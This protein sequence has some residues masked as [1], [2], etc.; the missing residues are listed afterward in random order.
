MITKASSGTVKVTVTDATKATGSASFTWTAKNTI[1]V[2]NPGAQTTTAG[3]PVSV[4]VPAADDDKATTLAWTASGLPSGLSIGAATGIITGEPALNGT[5]QVTVKVTD[6][7]G[8]A[9]STA[10]TWKVGD[11]ITVSAPGSEHSTVSIPIVPVKVTAA[12]SAKGRTLSYSAANLPPGLAIN[13]TTG[14]ISG[15]PA[16]KA[17]GYAATVT[18]KDGTGA[19]D[20]AP[21]G[22]TIANLVTVQTPASEQSFAGIAVSVHAKATDSDPAQKLSY[23]AAGLPASLAIN[24][25][26]GVIYGM[27]TTNGEGIVTVTVTDGAGSSGTAGVTWTVGDAITHPPPR[28]GVRHGGRGAYLAD[29]LH[30]HRA[31]RQSRACPCTACRPALPSRPARRRSSAGRL[32]PGTYPVTVVATGSLGD[33]QSMT[34]DDRRAAR[35]GRRSCRADPA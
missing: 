14:V 24:P 32:K 17:A 16:G 34:F 20:S 15:I 3:S 25:A 18:A 35:V 12:D 13:A 30:R 5:Y 9:A 4:A 33:S 7:T 6:K 8:S 22:W 2:A 31:A 26:T 21:I 28:H 10:F 19:S 23:A 29:R 27:P 11:L 1:V